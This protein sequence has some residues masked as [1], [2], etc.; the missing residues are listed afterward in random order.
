[1]EKKRI[2][3]NGTVHFILVHSY[4]VFLFVVIL[5]VIFDIFFKYKIFEKDIY[6]YIGFF[7][8]VFGS[9]I[10]FWAQ[11]VSSNYKIIKNKNNSKSFFEHGPYQ[12]LR[13]PTHLSIFIMALG[14]GLIINSFFSVIFT[15]IAYVITKI[16]FLK[17][18]EE[19]LENKY[20]E[21]YSEYKKKVKNWI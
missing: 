15:I 2:Y 4:L 18:E 16:F 10:I 8:L 1:M 21:V 19:I 14:F 20:G 9:I 7:M 5:G 11:K 17:K 3:K 12:Y 6:Q 13:N